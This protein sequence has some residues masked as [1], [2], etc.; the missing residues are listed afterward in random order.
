MVDML[1]DKVVTADHSTLVKIEL[2][3]ANKLVHM[4][5]ASV[6]VHQWWMFL[7]TLPLR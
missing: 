1:A 4:R 2:K 3:H 7:N 6:P 5:A